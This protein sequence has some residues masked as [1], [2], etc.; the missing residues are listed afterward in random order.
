MSYCAVQ[1]VGATIDASLQMQL[2]N[3]SG[4]SAD[5]NNH[6]HYLIQRTVEAI[7]YN[8]D[9]DE[10]NWASWDLT[11]SDIGS[12]GRS[13]DFFTDTNL[14]AGFYPVKPD[15]YDGVGFDRGHMCP[16]DDR[17]D[18]VTDNNM[19]FFMSN[20]IPQ[21][22]DNN[23]GVWVNFEDYCRTLAASGNELLIMCGPSGF[24]GSRILPSYAAAIPEFTWKIAVV[25]PLGPGTALSR[26]TSA[27]RVIAIKVPN[28]NGVSSVWQN[29][30][31][32][33]A[34]IQVD[35]G[36]TFFTAL[37]PDVASNLLN[38]VDGQTASPPVITDFSP[39]NGVVN[40]SVII[41]GANFTSASEVTFNGVSASFSVD[42][43]TQITATVPTNSTPGPISVTV[44]GGTTVSSN[45]YTV[46]GSTVDLTITKTHTG[47]FTQGDTG[48]TYVLQVSNV[49]TLASTGAVSVT[50]AVPAG[51]TVTAISG[52]GWNVDLPSLT[53]T[54]S[55]VLVPNAS[56]PPLTVTVAV[57]ANALTSVTNVATVT[58]GGD[59]NSSNNTASDPTT[60]LV[61][62]SG[63]Q[64]ITL[65]G[66]DV[67]VFP[68]STNN[69]GPS[70]FL[71]TTNA[72]NLTTSGFVRGS[73]VGTTGIGAGRAWGGNAFT[74]ASSTAAIAAHQFFTFTAAASSGNTV[75]FS[76]ISKFDYRRSATG[77]A[78]GLLQYEVGSGPFIDIVA[79]AYP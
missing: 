70:T 17:T 74:G 21:A 46:A 55:N 69:F 40:D 1:R 52:F 31:T 19:V 35:T 67:R 23:E 66:W 36:F 68:E 29:F 75:S 28:I 24:S 5:T 27:T 56:Y 65:L 61:S 33:A 59:A 9:L 18:N 26:I 7:D 73:G 60:I 48:D 13:P 32:S 72:A 77:P 14:P 39:T 2:G 62:Q 71:P 78:T 45:S 3:P 50:D 16:S 63:G 30:I 10:P 37:P 47:N 44:P 76:S 53:C 58:G 42:S 51:L 25:V 12:S 79:L 38:E 22:P 34:Q 64:T 49:G 54:R 57:A 20:I 11:A 6:T 4:A 8:A 41:T 43:D 15:D